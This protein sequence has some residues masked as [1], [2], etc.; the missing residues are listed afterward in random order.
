MAG[1]VYAGS[2][3]NYS[4]SGSTAFHRDYFADSAIAG[5]PGVGDAT[6]G[7]RIDTRRVDRS[8]ILSW[9]NYSERGSTAFHRGFLGE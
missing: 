6:G 8:D 5:Q 9:D 4:E 3:D 2:W 1:S 7:D